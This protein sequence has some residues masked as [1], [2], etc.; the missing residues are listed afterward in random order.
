MQY[1]TSLILF[2]GKLKTRDER[3]GVYKGIG[4]MVQWR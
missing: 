2:N 4:V 3:G 1:G